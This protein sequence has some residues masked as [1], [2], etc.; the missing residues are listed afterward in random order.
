MR[1]AIS[2]HYESARRRCK[3]WPTR[4][5]EASKVNESVITKKQR[6]AA[7]EYNAQRA[8]SEKRPPERRQ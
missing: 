2:S 6:E 5:Y 4:G 3:R 7:D 1:R 8:Q